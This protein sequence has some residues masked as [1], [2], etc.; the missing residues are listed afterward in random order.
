MHY[1]IAE[2]AQQEL[3]AMQGFLKRAQ[4]IYED[5]LGAYVKLVLR[6]PMHKIMV[7]NTSLDIVRLAT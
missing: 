3:G 7:R 5:N 4:G 2:V 1:F 6:R